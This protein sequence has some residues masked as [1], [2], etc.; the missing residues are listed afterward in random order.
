MAS[1]PQERSVEPQT[2]NRLQQILEAQLGNMVM[3]IAQLTVQLETVT[4]E[5]DA[6]QATLDAPKGDDGAVLTA[7]GG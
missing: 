6:L 5:R 7:V 4:A 3:Q 2:P 1:C